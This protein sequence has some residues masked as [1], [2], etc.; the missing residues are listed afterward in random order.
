MTY[1]SG[2]FYAFNKNVFFKAQKSNL[3]DCNR[4]NSTIFFKRRKKSK[5]HACEKFNLIH[6]NF[7]EF[8][9]EMF[10]IIDVNSIY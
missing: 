1:E 5:K 2:A 9:N 6:S 8:S 10:K 7:C 3:Q 4:M